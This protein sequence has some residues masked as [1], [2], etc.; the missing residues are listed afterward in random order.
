MTNSAGWG[1]IV[2]TRGCQERD[3]GPVAQ[4]SVSRA[5]IGFT[6]IYI[7]IGRIG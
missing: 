1:L 7:A 5:L 3:A 4:F 2:Q 6:E